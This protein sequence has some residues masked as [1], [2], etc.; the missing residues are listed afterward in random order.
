M[1]KQLV[2]LLCLSLA[3]PPAFAGGLLSGLFG[4]GR[5]RQ[6]QQVQQVQTF[7]CAAPVAYAAPVY[8]QAY[9][10]PTVVAAL[11]SA[12]LVVNADAYQ[13]GVSFNNFA[14]YQAQNQAA[15]AAQVASKP[16]EIAPPAAPRAAAED[17][18]PRVAGAQ[19]LKAQCIQC[20]QKGRS[21]KSGFSIF[22]EKGDMFVGLP[23]AEIMERITS[24][25]PAQRM[26]PRKTL[27]SHD[28]MS[29]FRLASTAV[30]Q[31]SGMQTAATSGKVA[32]LPF[33]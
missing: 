1:R 26:P 30:E 2:V 25:D 11:P 32:S 5:R 9:V 18:D 31:N 33:D 3:T 28:V 27:A 15:Q 20:H 8:Q 23:Y 19:V 7:H 21:P 24:A 10:A 17:E 16:S 14:Q 12:G 29:V 6:V 22:D 4:G 13:Y